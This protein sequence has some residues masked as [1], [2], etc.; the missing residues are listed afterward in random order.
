MRF[1]QADQLRCHFDELVVLDPGQRALQRHLDRR[2]QA[3]GFVLAGGTDVGELLTPQHV[4]L[5]VIV[6]RRPLVV[7]DGAAITTFTVESLSV[8]REFQ[9]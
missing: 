5:E 1:A 3:E 6:Q 8:L 7:V 2:R 4:D 9:S